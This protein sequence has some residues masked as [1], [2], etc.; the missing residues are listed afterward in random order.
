MWLAQ[1]SGKWAWTD[2][3]AR[4]A[5]WLRQQAHTNVNG[6]TL[7]MPHALRWFKKTHD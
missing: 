4:Y 6:V 5:R 2:R 7:R 1:C 3:G